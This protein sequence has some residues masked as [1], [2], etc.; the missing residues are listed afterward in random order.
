VTTV[1]PLGNRV[2]VGLAVPEPLTADV[3]LAAAEGLALTPGAPVVVVLKATATRLVA[4][5]D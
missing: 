4:P 5:S 3:T 2:R 1:T